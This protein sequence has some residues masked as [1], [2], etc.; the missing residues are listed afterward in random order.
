MPITWREVNLG[1]RKCVLCHMSSSI[2]LKQDLSK[3]SYLTSPFLPI[4]LL[5]SSG[6]GFFWSP[7]PLSPSFSEQ[8]FLSAL[9]P[10]LRLPH[11]CPWVHWWMRN[12]CKS[13]FE[14]HLHG[15]ILVPYSS[16]KSQCHLSVFQSGCDCSLLLASQNALEPTDS[17]QNAS[18]PT[19]YSQN[20]L[21]SMVSLIHLSFAYLSPC[22]HNFQSILYIYYLCI[23]HIILSVHPPF[24]IYHFS[25]LYP[26]YPFMYLLLVKLP[27]SVSI[28][29]IFKSI[30]LSLN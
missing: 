12:K 13:R 30:D 14:T 20:A 9:L 8:F 11:I 25:A 22:L 5:P 4:N 6:Q 26:Y 28:W 23:C 24:S 19:D 17:S 18:E 10:H 1:K 27:S 21:E 15:F 16:V 29:Y 3:W 7:L 2:I